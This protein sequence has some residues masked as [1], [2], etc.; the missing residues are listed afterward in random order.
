MG[1]QFEKIMLEEQIDF[2][3]ANERSANVMFGGQKMKLLSRKD[4][5]ENDPI[6]FPA[7]DAVN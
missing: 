7:K 6:L 3:K 4:S 1:P 5:I 2:G